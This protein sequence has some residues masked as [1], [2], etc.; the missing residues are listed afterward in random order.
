MTP[1]A[2]PLLAAHSVTT[3]TVVRLLLPAHCRP[4]L[5]DLFCGAGGAGWGYYL[6]GFDVTGGDIKPQPHYPPLLRFFQRD[7]L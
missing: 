5:L 7:P 3:R 4:R 2:T 6:A 1:D